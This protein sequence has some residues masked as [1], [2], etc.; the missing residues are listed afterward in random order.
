MADQF[1]RLKAALADR[2]DLERELGAGGMATVYLAVDL[3]HHRKVAVKVL[4]SELAG[5]LGPD[6]FNREIEIAAQLQHPHIVAVYD[7]GQADGFFYYVMPLVEGE[8]L[9]TRIK[10]DGPLPIHEAIHILREIVDALAYAHQRGVVHRDIKPDNVMLSGRHA[11][12]TDFGVAKAVSAAGSETLTTVGVS[13]GTPTYMAPEQAVGEAD[14]DNRVDIYALGAVGYELL[15][16]APPFERANAQ[17]MLSAHVLE[18]PVDVEL[19]RPGIPPGLSTL[20]MRCLEKDREARW[21]NAEE[22]LPLLEALA[23]PSGGITPTD[24]RPLR[25]RMAVKKG[26]R[27]RIAAA[28][29][30]V[31]VLLLVAGFLLFRGGG[32]GKIN[33]IAV[34]PIQDLSGK[35]Q[36][37]VDG[38][39]DAL[40]NA[41]A[42]ANV[43][44]VVPR[45]EVMRFRDGGQT[46]REIAD[47]LKAGAIIE[48]TVFRDGNRVRIN[49]QMVEPRTLKHLWVQTYERDVS[50]VLGAQKAIVDQ[51]ATEV[52]AVLR[53]PAPAS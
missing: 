53:G 43:V 25:A 1:E 2:Y 13:L 23:T 50:D 26:R 37:F 7:S 46:T 30:G 31:L 14:I 28:V 32:S 17:A 34:L 41:L 51:I 44:G 8:S 52:D 49:M 36:P 4:R 39:H 38:I 22:M 15:T 27:G 12:V 16:G 24:T 5:A 42:Q 20:I 47:A 19:K 33:E 45:S 6:R 35:D 48:G 18:K 11:A 40:I 3:K 9:R 10:R 29:V 21:K